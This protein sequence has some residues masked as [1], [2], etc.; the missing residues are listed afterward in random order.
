MLPQINQD[1]S[2]KHVE[3]E[4]VWKKKKEKL[5]TI[6]LSVLSTLR[7]QLNKEHFLKDSLVLSHLNIDRGRQSALV[8]WLLLGSYSTI[9]S[10]DFGFQGCPMVQNG[11]QNPNPH[12]HAPLRKK[13]EKEKCCHFILNKS[14]LRDFFQKLHLTT[15][16]IELL[17]N[18][19]ILNIEKL[20]SFQL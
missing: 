14:L 3:E 7:K 20:V 12:I 16:N 8:Q 11:C 13:G 10:S 18:I 15:T 17:L 5:A 19:Q 2:L 6:S 9:L 1:L 4:W